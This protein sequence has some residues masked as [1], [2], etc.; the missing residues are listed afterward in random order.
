MITAPDM[1]ICTDD[2]GYLQ[3]WTLPSHTVCKADVALL[4]F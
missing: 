2:D 1:Y 3:K 4:M